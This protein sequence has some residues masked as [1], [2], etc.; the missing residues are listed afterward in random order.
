VPEP[1]PA[2]LIFTEPDAADGSA[3]PR[4]TGPLG[5]L[6]ASAEVGADLGAN[7]LEASASVNIGINERPTATAWTWNLFR[8]PGEGPAVT[9]QVSSAVNWKGVLAG[10]GA[11]GTGAAVT[12]RL[13][14]LEGNRTIAST[15]VHTLERRESAL[16][17][18]GA[19]DVGSES[20]DLQAVLVPGRLYELRLSV[21]CEAYSGLL[22]VVTHCI[23]GPSDVYEDGYVH[24]G[25]RRILFVP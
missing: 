11:A 13:A 1:T 12:I 7:Q 9:A 2:E 24:W 16:S 23:F 8:A 15:V 25:E 3:S 5:V 4:S 22:G 10:N 21:T 20:A 14:V 18:G 17:A 19:D 6:Y